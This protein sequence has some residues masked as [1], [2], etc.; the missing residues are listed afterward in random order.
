MRKF[1]SVLAVAG[2]IA[3]PFAAEAAKDSIVIGMRLEPPGLDP[4]TGAAAAISQITLY[5]VF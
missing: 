4:T 2:A 1:V 3:I 5:N